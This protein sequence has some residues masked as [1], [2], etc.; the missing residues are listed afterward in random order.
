VIYMSTE[1]QREY[2]YLINGRPA[3]TTDATP[4]QAQVLADAGFEPVLDYV[5]IQRTPH[6]TKVVSSD[7]SLN[8]RDDSAEFFAFNCGVSYELTVNTHSIW[9]GEAT[10]DIAKIRS[11][12]KVSEDHDLVWDHGEQAPEVLPRQGHFRLDG[13]GVEHLRTVRPEHHT[14]TYIYFVGDNE[15]KTDQEQLTGAQIT[16]QIA[17]WNPANSLVLEGE[18]SEPDEMIRPT[19]AVNFKCRATPAH[20]IVVPPATFG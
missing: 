11:F 7:D 18:G 20:F 10:I 16:A 1:E 4:T 8:L 19:T 6:G 2:P 3:K 9:W 5:L 13:G 15:Y 12:G 14:V 17:D